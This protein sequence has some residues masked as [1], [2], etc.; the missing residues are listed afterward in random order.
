MGE[1]M[2]SPHEIARGSILLASNYLAVAAKMRK[3]RA[4]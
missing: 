3:Q 4:S 1:K 2:Q